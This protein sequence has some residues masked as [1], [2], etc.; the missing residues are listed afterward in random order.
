MDCVHVDILVMILS[1]SFAGYQHLRKVRTSRWHSGE[2]PACQ[3]GSVKRCGF[4][5]WVG[6]RKWL[7]TAVFLPGELHG[8]RS[9][10]GYSPQD[11]KELHMSER[12]HTHTH[13]QRYKGTWDLCYFLTT[14]SDSDYLKV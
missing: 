6:S 1:F 4:S 12:E 11:H 10:V 7:P 2:E 13:T 14:A 3:C 8:Q 5:P 9:L